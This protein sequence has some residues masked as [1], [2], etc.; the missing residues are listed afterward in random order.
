MSFLHFMFQ[1]DVTVEWKEYCDKLKCCLMCLMKAFECHR[2]VIIAQFV[3]LLFLHVKRADLLFD[4]L[5]DP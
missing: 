4:L 3:S 1:C 2:I 5:F